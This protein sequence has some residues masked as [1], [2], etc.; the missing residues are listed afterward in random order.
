LKRKAILIFGVGIDIIEISRIENEIKKGGEDFLDSIFTSIEIEYCRPRAN[1]SESFAAR[2]AAKEAFLKALGTG[3]RDGIGWKDIEVMKNEQGKPYFVF[4]GKTKD[5][6]AE[7][8]ITDVHLS[9]SHIK[10]AATAVVIIE[11]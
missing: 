11:K 10:S 8:E 4:Y 9:F 7:N 2:F 1:A 6:L 3:W 5:L